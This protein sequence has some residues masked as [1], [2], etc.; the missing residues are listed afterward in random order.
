MSPLFKPLAIFLSANLLLV[1]VSLAVP[2][3]KSGTINVGYVGEKLDHIP[4]G[5]KKLVRQKMLG[6]INQNYYEFHNPTDLTA[7]H[8]NA[9]STILSHNE[10][11][12]NGDLARLS[13][14]ANLDYIFVTS[15]SNISEDQNRVMLEGNVFRYNRKSDDVYRYE[16]LSYAEDL[17]LHIQAMKRELVETIPHSV[18]GL[19]RNRIYV[20]VGVAIVIGF[21]MSQS[22]GNMF[23]F[24]QDGDNDEEPV[25]PVGD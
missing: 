9:I 7:I 6:L 23:K 5:Y 11:S 4:D 17:D 15:L 20:L 3:T 16:I 2:Q 24:L 8:S 21:A 13:E 10:N 12:F 19:G 22:F 14:D 18:H 25:P 1:Q